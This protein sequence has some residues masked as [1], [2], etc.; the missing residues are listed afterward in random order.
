[1]AEPRVARPTPWRSWRRAHGQPVAPAP[2]GGR[3]RRATGSAT[4]PRT[5]RSGSSARSP[6]ARS[7]SA[8]AVRSGALERERVVH[9]ET[10]A[11]EASSPRRTRRCRWARS[12]SVRCARCC[13]TRRGLDRL[14][15]A[16]A[17]RGRARRASRSP[18]RSTSSTACS[19]RSPGAPAARADGDSGGGRTIAYLD[20]MRDLDVT[21]GPAVLEELRASLPPVLYAS[22]WW[23]GKV[24]DARRRAARR[25]RRGH[26]GPLAPLLGPADGRRLR[27]LEPARRRAGRAA[28]PLGG[29]RGERAAEASPTGRP[30]GTARG[31]HSADLQIARPSAEA[32]ARGDFLIV[33]GD[34]HGGDN[35]LAQG[36]F[37]L[38]H[39]DPAALL[40]R[41]ARRGRARACTSRRRGAA[42]SR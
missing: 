41:I 31:Y 10:W 8:T 2:L 37:G 12:P 4:A 9:F 20:C 19:R 40:R 38:R 27:A 30:P 26:D 18:P 35:P 29:G 11:M 32:I 39:P 5:T 1:M 28:A 13:A 42:W 6:G 7:A 34:F 23:C 33:L 17:A 24:F 15:A 36:L 21:L 25:D 16:R 3:G 14:E 22:R